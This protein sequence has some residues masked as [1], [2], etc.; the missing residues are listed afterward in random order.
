MENNFQQQPDLKSRQVQVRSR[1][2]NKFVGIG[3][4]IIL[5]FILGRLSSKLNFVGK[6][7]ERQQTAQN[8]TSTN[9]NTVKDAV[10]LIKLTDLKI[11]AQTVSYPS[12]IFTLDSLARAP[13]LHPKG[14]HEGVNQEIKDQI[15]VNDGCFDSTVFDPNQTYSLIGVTLDVANNSNAAI[16]GDLAK[17]AYYVSQGRE[18]NI[19]Y[20]QADIGFA[21]YGVSA[22]QDKKLLLSFWVPDNQDKLYFVFGPKIVNSSDPPKE[23]KLENFFEQ[24]IEIDFNQK[25]ADLLTDPKPKTLQLISPR[26]GEVLCLGQNFPIEWETPKG[27]TSVEIMVRKYEDAPINTFTIQ[28]VPATSSFLN[29]SSGTGIYTWNVGRVVS[30]YGSTEVPGPLLPGDAYQIIVSGVVDGRSEADWN[31]T[32]FAISADC[33]KR[34]F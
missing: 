15:R 13:G 3:L 29:G 19:R 33:P 30:R 9:Q 6:A 26:G 8:A 12:V 4:L 10:N 1:H 31:R 22:Y 28:T 21:S 34:Q 23:Q 20:A 11:S 14:C 7:P 24:V 25:T 27:M 17:L 16:Q 2:I 18:T 5:T 32:A